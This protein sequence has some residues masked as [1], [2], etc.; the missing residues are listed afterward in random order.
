M[1]TDV[2]MYHLKTG[3]HSVMSR[4]ELHEHSLF[5]ICWFIGG[6]VQILFKQPC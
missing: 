3:N 4:D 2:V 1:Y 6:G 5:H